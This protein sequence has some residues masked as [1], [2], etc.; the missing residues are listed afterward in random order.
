MFIEI[1]YNIQRNKED[2]EIKQ[3]NK[4]NEH[5]EAQNHSKC[6]YTFKIVVIQL[7]HTYDHI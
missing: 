4:G 2:Q 3:E 5:E 7:I 1:F 6:V